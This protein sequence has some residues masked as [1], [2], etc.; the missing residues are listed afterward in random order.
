MYLLY[1]YVLYLKHLR[2]VCYSCTASSLIL[3]YVFAR[4]KDNLL[5][6]ISMKF[7]L[8]TLKKLK[9]G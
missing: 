1:M 8:D 5:R 3:L 7:N 6:K 9:Y 4:N 2:V